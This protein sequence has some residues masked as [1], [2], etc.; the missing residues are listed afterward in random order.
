M[1]RAKITR[2][3]ITL[4]STLTSASFPPLGQCVSKEERMPSFRTRKGIKLYNRTEASVKVSPG[5]VTVLLA[6]VRDGDQDALAQLIPLVY[7]ELRRLA[8]HLLREERPGHTLQATALR[9]NS[10]ELRGSM[11]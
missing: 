2:F 8:G 3:V 4:L 10:H 7:R 11:S 6:R 9:S 5:E 1:S